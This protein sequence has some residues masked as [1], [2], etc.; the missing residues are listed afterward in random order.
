MLPAADYGGSVLSLEVGFPLHG[1]LFCAYPAPS[2]TV[3]PERN[4]SG[5]RTTASWAKVK[6]E[7]L[8]FT[9]D[10]LERVQR[11]DERDLGSAPSFDHSSISRACRRLVPECDYLL[12]AKALVSANPSGRGFW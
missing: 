12:G 5:M 6:L 1:C 10:K 4:I 8:P 2:T 11:F 9:V 3:M 7:C